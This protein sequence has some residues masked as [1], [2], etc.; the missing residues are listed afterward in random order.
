MLIERLGS[1]VETLHLHSFALSVYQRVGALNI[2]SYLRNRGFREAPD[3]LAIPPAWMLMAVAGS[4]EA[5]AFLDGGRKAAQSIR[6]ILRRNG[7][8]MEDLGAILDFGCGCGRVLRF[9]KELR[10]TEIHGAD[11]NARLAQ[12]CRNNIP[13]VRVGSNELM[14]PVA[15]PDAMFGLIY[16]LSVFTHLPEHVQMAWMSEFR[17]ILPSGGLLLLS[18][19][20]AHYL[21]RL[22]EAERRRFLDGQAVTRH[23]R[24]AG[25]NLCCAFHPEDWVR[26]KLAMDFEVVDFVPEGALGN[27]RQDLWL[28]RRKPGVL[29]RT[30]LPLH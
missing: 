10:R 16:A 19:H 9:W 20:G 14:P 27:P 1:V 13:F 11:Y 21:P 3:G 2:R 6:D 15:Y 7:S 28:F 5:G 4:A 8:Q 29:P 12:W 25:M 17:R 22:H 30:Y 24:S 26:K 23:S 18:L